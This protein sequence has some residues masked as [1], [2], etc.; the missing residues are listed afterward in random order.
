LG[1]RD[2]RITIQSQPR[3]IVHEILY[4]KYSRSKIKRDGKEGA[5]GVALKWLV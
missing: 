4:G 1:G 5:G 3:Q 2:Q